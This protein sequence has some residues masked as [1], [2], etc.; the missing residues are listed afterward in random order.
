M[1][2]I[3]HPKKSAPIPHEI[4][5]ASIDGLASTHD[6]NAIGNDACRDVS[7]SGDDWGNNA[8]A[9]GQV[10]RIHTLAPRGKRS[11]PK[12]IHKETSLLAASA[13]CRT[14]HHRPSTSHI[15]LHVIHAIPQITHQR[16]AA[17]PASWALSLVMP[18][19]ASR[20]CSTDVHARG[21]RTT[22]AQP[23]LGTQAAAG[24]RKEIIR[25]RQ[26]RDRCLRTL[27]PCAYGRSL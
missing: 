9:S 15:T 21:G 6:R 17:K 2:K 18:Q 14:F 22:S 19:Q 16:V 10:P 8:V 20:T 13:R 24:I 27:C 23:G 26:G 3:T 7:D 25:Q 1:H 4:Q 11:V 5:T 12:T